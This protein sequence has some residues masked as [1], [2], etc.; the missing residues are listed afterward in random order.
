MFSLLADD[1]VPPTQSSL[2]Q[3][4]V[5]LKSGVILLY[6]REI[7]KW[8]GYSNLPQSHRRSP[9][10]R[11]VF[12][13]IISGPIVSSNYVGGCHTLVPL[14]VMISFN[15]IRS[16]VNHSWVVASFLGDPYLNWFFKILNNETL[17]LSQNHKK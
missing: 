8:L 12:Q 5:V 1:N 15:H 9:Q 7:S 11:N 14:F 6:M 17:L 10:L 16:H 4:F 13:E 2:T 3:D